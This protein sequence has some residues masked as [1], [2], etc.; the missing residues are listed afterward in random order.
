MGADAAG[1]DGVGALMVLVLMES[2]QTVLVL[3]ESVRNGNDADGVGAEGVGV[4]GVASVLTRVG[5]DGVGAPPWIMQEK[6][7]IITLLFDH[8]QLVPSMVSSRGF[9]LRALIEA[10]ILPTTE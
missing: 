1:A 2:V 10:M 3:S 4:D 8:Q 7:S 5:A 9:P 6:W